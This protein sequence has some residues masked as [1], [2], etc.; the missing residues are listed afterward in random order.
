MKYRKV[1]QFQ[2]VVECSYQTE[3]AVNKIINTEYGSL[4][5]GL[6]T[7]KPGFC[8]ECSGLTL[9]TKS[10]MRGAAFHDMGY[11]LIRNGLLDR[12]WKEPFDAL[13]LELCLKDGMWPIRA[14]WIYRAVLLFGDSSVNPVNRVK[15]QTA[16]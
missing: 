8:F 7:L 16:P 1:Q 3:I 9:K 12:F 15:V 2:I 5:K 6:I 10:T 14:N 4:N 11:Y 13:L